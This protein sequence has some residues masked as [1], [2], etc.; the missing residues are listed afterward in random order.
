MLELKNE[1]VALCNKSGLP[2]E[3]ILFVIKDIYR[4]AQDNLAMAEEQQRR[5]AEQAPKIE[6]V[7]KD[8]PKA[9]GEVIEEE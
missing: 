1:I 2:L 4:D 6:E 9:E 8:I 3:A 5:H 7:E